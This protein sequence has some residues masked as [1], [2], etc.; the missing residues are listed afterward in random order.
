MESL[1]LFINHSKIRF[2]GTPCRN[3]KDIIMQT[4]YIEMVIYHDITLGWVID[5]LWQSSG[6]YKISCNVEKETV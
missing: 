1:G 2:S 5:G 3:N 6:E 4:I